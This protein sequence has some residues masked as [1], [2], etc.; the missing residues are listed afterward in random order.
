MGLN[1]ANRVLNHP[2]MVKATKPGVSSAVALVTTV[3]TASKDA[4]NCIYYVY[5]SL[6][7]ERIPEDKRKFVA[8]LDLSN[9]IL[10]VLTQCFLGA[11]MAKFTDMIFEKTVVPKHFSEAGVKMWYQ[12]LKS[13]QSLAEF[14]EKM[15]K[16]K[17]VA[18]LGLAAISALV[19]T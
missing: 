19:G 9:G 1:I 11:A 8:A 12:K 2:W 6:N 7:N 18:K 13:T 10:N 15:L 16:G 3:S 5:Q 14:S 17:R 4:V